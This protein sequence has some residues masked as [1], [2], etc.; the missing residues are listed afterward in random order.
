MSPPT[1]E[2]IVLT[3][4]GAVATLTM[5][6]EAKKNAFNY[7]MYSDW[8]AALQW[9]KSEE[10]IVALIVT[11]SGTFFSSG[12]DLSSGDSPG[13]QHARYAPVGHF[14]WELMHFPKPVIAAVNGPAIGVG[15]TLLLHCD[16]IYAAKSTFFQTPFARIAVVPEFCSSLLMPELLGNSLANEMLLGE[17]RLTSAEALRVGFVSALY[18]SAEQTVAAARAMAAAM[19][20]HTFAERTL[21]LFK[22]MIKSP[23][24]MA[25]MQ[26][27]YEE[28]MDRL[29]ERFR[30]G[31]TAEA[32]MKFMQA[33][34][35]AK[36]KAKL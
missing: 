32:A 16:I 36:N 30:N 22:R 33:Q 35:A 23:A 20:A 26:A 27:V 21:P 4:D 14:M 8:T 3:V 6:R 18:D 15:L 2:T 19:A 25:Q 29:T 17:K 5:N 24:R 9:L 28:E 7:Q 13:D 34:R 10:A 11:G 12:A 31:E 1:F